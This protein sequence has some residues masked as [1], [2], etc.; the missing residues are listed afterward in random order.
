MSKK[1]R[2]ITNGLHYVIQVRFLWNWWSYEEWCLS[3]ISLS[4]P[5]YWICP[6]FK[7]KEAVQRKINYLLKEPILEKQHKEEIRAYKKRP[8]TI[9]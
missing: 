4:E 5:G 9:S 7:S 2:I 6:E 3:G 1:Y 8:W